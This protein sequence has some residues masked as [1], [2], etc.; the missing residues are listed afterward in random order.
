MTV[1][2]ALLA[3][4]G[5]FALPLIVYGFFAWIA[6]FE[7]CFRPIEP[8]DDA[9]GDLPKLPEGFSLSHFGTSSM[10]CRHDHGARG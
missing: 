5:T 4:A 2:G 8:S 1:L 7:E 3:I 9:M 6:E 10:G